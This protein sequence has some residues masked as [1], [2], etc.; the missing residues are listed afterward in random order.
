MPPL[1]EI[2][3]LTDDEALDDEVFGANADINNLETTL[4]CT[5]KE[6]YKRSKRYHL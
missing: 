1:E 2:Y 6:F 4:I 3:V 5:N